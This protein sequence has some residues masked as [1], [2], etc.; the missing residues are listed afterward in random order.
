MQ[1]THI[2]KELAVNTQSEQTHSDGTLHLTPQ[3]KGRAIRLIQN[4]IKVYGHILRTITQEQARTWRDQNDAPNGWSALEV[5]CHVADFDEFFCHRVQMMLAEEYPQL[6]AYDHEA[7]AV[8]RAYNQQDKDAVY[9]RF[10]ESR[11]RFVALFESLNDEQW[12]RA[13]VH[14]ESGH[15]TVLDALMQVG[16]HDTLHLEQ[17]MRIIADARP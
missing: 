5:L 10:V 15:F 1:P 16:S 17:M 12:D 8:E 7:L 11:A 3:S 9:A 13:G 14:P 2:L 6:P 4:S